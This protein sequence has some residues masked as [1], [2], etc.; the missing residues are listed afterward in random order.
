MSWL[1]PLSHFGETLP[2]PTIQAHSHCLRL[3]L[4]PQNEGAR[5]L[6]PSPPR[7]PHYGTARY[8][9]IP[10]VLLASS[11]ILTLLMQ[12]P[13]AHPALFA[14]TTAP[15]APSISICNGLNSGEQLY[16]QR[17]GSAREIFGWA[18]THYSR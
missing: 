4:H 5:S 12:C 9:I 18:S 13:Q 17:V 16:A 2:F 11:T 6:S 8:R 10:T 1:S 7:S 3:D 14:P 15:S